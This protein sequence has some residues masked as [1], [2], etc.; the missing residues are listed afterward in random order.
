MDYQEQRRAYKALDETIANLKPG[1]GININRLL[2]EVTR[3]FAVSML[4]IKKRIALLIKADD[5][6]VE[7]E[8][9]IRREG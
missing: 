5:H 4:S 3:T 2:L 8:G 6:L 1:Q 9:M 7:Q